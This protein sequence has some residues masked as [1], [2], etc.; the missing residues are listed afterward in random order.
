MKIK[1]KKSI[2]KN[3]LPSFLFVIFH[4]LSLISFRN[5][6]L[7]DFICLPFLI[8]F[9]LLFVKRK[10]LLFLISAVYLLIIS[11]VYF[12]NINI[13]LFIYFAWILR[14]SLIPLFLFFYINNLSEDDSIKN[15]KPLGILFFCYQLYFVILGIITIGHYSNIFSPRYYGMGFPFYSLGQDSHMFG[16]ALAHVFLVSISLLTNNRYKKIILYPNFSKILTVFLFLQS[17]STG[18]RGVVIVY[19]LFVLYK[20]FFL[21]MDKFKETRK[22]FII[23]KYALKSLSIIFFLSSTLS[24]IF[25]KLVLSQFNIDPRVIFRLQRTFTLTFD[26]SQEISRQPIIN[27]LSEVA[28]NPLNY[29]FSFDK[30]LTT[31]DSGALLITYNA[32]LIFLIILVSLWVFIFLKYNTKRVSSFIFL[33]S[34]LYF[35]FNAPHIMIPRYW[36]ALIIPIIFAL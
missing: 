6:A 16:P 11:A 32:G 7:F 17:L 28:N 20:L 26:P 9:T 12:L 31:I 2:I 3:F 27:L 13:P 33:S 4:I 22:K 24:L 10:K 21:L 19:G 34:L 36:I 29:I 15:S 5:H 25:L 30:F 8:P 1:I 23:S 18:S 14:F 35:L